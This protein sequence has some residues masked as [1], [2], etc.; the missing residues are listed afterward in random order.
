MVE[1]GELKTSGKILTSTSQLKA[2]PTEGFSKGNTT[3]RASNTSVQF[4]LRDEINNIDSIGVIR[5]E[6]TMR[7]DKPTIVY[8]IEYYIKGHRFITKRSYSEFLYL[9]KEVNIEGICLR[10]LI[11]QK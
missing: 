3:W 7:F 9:Y 1:S 8:I 6:D 5:H 10:P 11:D 4:D 2:H